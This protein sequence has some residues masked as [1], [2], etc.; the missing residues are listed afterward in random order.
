MKTF[1]GE[2]PAEGRSYLGRVDGYA[3]MAQLRTPV[4]EDVYRCEPGFYRSISTKVRSITVQIVMVRRSALDWLDGPYEEGTV[5]VE[6]IGL[7]FRLALVN[8]I[9]YVGWPLA[10]CR[11]HDTSI[12]GDGDK[13]PRGFVLGHGMNLKRARAVLDDRARDA[14]RDRVASVTSE[15]GGQHI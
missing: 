6:A 3:C 12:A 11:R 4:D 10:H 7:C 13:I 2:D 15:L 5:L 9:L 8:R 1:L 14:I